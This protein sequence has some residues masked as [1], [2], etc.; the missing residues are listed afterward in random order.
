MGAGKRKYLKDETTYSIR[1]FSHYVQSWW[2]LIGFNIA[3]CND[4]D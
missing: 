1:N 3:Q 4:D 2:D